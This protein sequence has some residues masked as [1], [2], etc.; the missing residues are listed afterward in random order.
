MRVVQQHR[1]LEH[2]R[3][4][5]VRGG[6]PGRRDRSRQ[7]VLRSIKTVED[8]GIE[9]K[10]GRKLHHLVATDV[11]LP[12]A[13]LGLTDKTIKD[14][15]GTLDFW[16]SDDGMPQVVAATGRWTQASGKNPAAPATLNVEFALTN[17]GGSVSVASARPDL[18]A[19]E[20][21]EVPLLDGLADRLGVSEGAPAQVDRLVLGPEYATVFGSSWR[22]GHLAQPWTRASTRGHRGVSGV[23]GFKLQSNKAATLAGSRARRLEFRETYKGRKEYSIVVLAAHGGKLYWLAVRIEQADHAGRPGIVRLSSCRHSSS[24]SRR[25]VP[26]PGRGTDEPTGGS[27]ETGDG[28]GLDRVIRGVVIEQ[29]TMD[30]DPSDLHGGCPAGQPDAR[31]RDRRRPRSTGSR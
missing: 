22:P 15:T 6:V 3:W 14:V 11:A 18:E 30:G 23:K 25:L 29:A 26:A 12:P 31:Q 10:N 13:V 1:L 17:V 21:E 7:R 2:G 28:D 16:V 27:E 4:T 19:G 8:T 20:V 9:T 24:G 5:L